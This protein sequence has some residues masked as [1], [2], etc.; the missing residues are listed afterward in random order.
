[1]TRPGNWSLVDGD[2][3]P[4]R[5]DGI[6]RKGDV[7]EHIAEVA[8]EAR[9][10]LQAIKDRDLNDVWEGEAA[11]RFAEQI[12]G[13]FLGNL[14][15]LD[16]SFNLAGHALQDY[17][18]ELAE[19]QAEADQLLRQA[20]QA[21]QDEEAADRR[22]GSADH[23]LS[24][25]KDG[26]R[27]ADDAVAALNREYYTTLSTRRADDTTYQA[28]YDNWKRRYEAARQR[29][30]AE[31]NLQTE[32]T[33]VRDRA[34]DDRDHARQSL[35]RARDQIAEIRE[36]R[37][38]AEK[39]AADDLA[40]AHELGIKNK[41]FWDKVKDTFNAGIDWIV[42]N[43]DVLDNVLGWISTIAGVLALCVGWIPVI[44]QALAAGLIVIS[45][46]AQVL[47]ALV[48]I[49]GACKGKRSWTTALFE[50]AMAAA[51]IATL[52]MASK[53]TS[54][55]KGA[56][57]AT[58]ASKAKTI[59][60]AM[61]KFA[62]GHGMGKV[63]DGVKWFNKTFHPF[64]PTKLAKIATDIPSD[65]K[66]VYKL[67]KNGGSAFWRH[68]G[69]AKWVRRAAEQRAGKIITEGYKWIG[70]KT[71]IDDRVPDSEDVVDWAVRHKGDILRSLVPLPLA[72]PVRTPLCGV[73]A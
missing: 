60:G 12:E 9:T 15:K 7:F 48:N 1:M 44:G 40:Q 14:K 55:V 65:V 72:P 37:E 57:M 52:G 3:A 41:G 19:L 49:I 27:R 33:S 30:V 70:D 5:P 4:G 54:A 17:A 62:E 46:T 25:A 53:G 51:D 45:V 23:D 59:A 29:L 18:T 24:T 64:D 47:K 39:E 50:T 58:K 43:I 21:D 34:T 2:P 16:E 42:D 11:D 36:R 68:L 26:V 6:R 8:G 28:R 13:D 69:D 22:V 20:A 66:K 73:A 56:T 32:C 10:E 67:A 38:R 63:V 35:K 61:T 31:Q 71:G